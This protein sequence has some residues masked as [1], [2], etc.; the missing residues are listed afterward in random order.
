MTTR[1]SIARRALVGTAAAAALGL[2]LAAPATAQPA[3]TEPC[4]QRVAVVNNGGFTMSFA[5]STREG[6]LSA[7]TDTYAINEWRV[8][9][10]TTTPLAEGVDI[11]PVVSATAGSD[12]AGNRF[13][14][15]C[16]NGQTATFTASGTVTD[17]QVTLIT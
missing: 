16:R 12:V 3:A 9:D 17:Y 1:R 15:Y 10:L 14:S 11:R 13:V 2:G 8:I 5:V 4:V 6:Q 7:P